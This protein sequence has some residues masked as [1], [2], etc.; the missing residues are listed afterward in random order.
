MYSALGFEKPQVVITSKPT[1]I[2]KKGGKSDNMNVSRSTAKAP[3]A[4]EYVLSHLYFIT[5]LT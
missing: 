1:P 3:R 2:T 4:P 5:M